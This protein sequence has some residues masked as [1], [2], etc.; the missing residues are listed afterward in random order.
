ML[1]VEC[2]TDG[3]TRQPLIGI[4]E[5]SFAVRMSEN[6]IHSLEVL[7][8][9]D[10]GSRD[11]APTWPPMCHLHAT[12]S[13]SLKGQPCNTRA[14]HLTSVIKQSS[15]DKCS[16][17]EGRKEG[18]KDASARVLPP[19]LSPSTASWQRLSCP[20]CQRIIEGME[21]EWGGGRHVD[22]WRFTLSS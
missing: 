5:C 16:R 15:P 21:H 19:S 1:A 9:R 14:P 3:A 6:S 11:A 7:V 10:F 2:R 8:R 18:R 17:K 4:N 13:H 22:R 20:S 12:H